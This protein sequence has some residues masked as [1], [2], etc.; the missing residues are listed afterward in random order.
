VLRFIVAK[1]QISGSLNECWFRLHLKAML[2]STNFPVISQGI[3]GSLD[4]CVNPLRLKF[5]PRWRWENSHGIQAASIQGTGAAFRRYFCHLYQIMQTET[6]SD[7]LD[8]LQI[9]A[10][11]LPLGEEE[12]RFIRGFPGFTRL[13]VWWRWR[14][15]EGNKTVSYITMRQ[16]AENW[17]CLKHLNST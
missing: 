5:S 14:E 8:P 10:A 13:S 11:Y 7:T 16:T 9:S 15:S 17:F 2:I 6:A 12:L 4:A 3:K 1:E